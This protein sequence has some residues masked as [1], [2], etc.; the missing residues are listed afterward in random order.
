M[1]MQLAE[2]HL[3]D[4]TCHVKKGIMLRVVCE[5]ALED[6]RLGK[7]ANAITPFWRIISND[8]PLFTKLNRERTELELIRHL[9]E[10]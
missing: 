6:Y 9:A 10:A 7:P 5:A 1:R 8:T 3:A 2:N 4:A